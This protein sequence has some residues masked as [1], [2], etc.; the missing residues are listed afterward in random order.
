ML[1]VRSARSSQIAPSVAERFNQQRGTALI[2]ITPNWKAMR[3]RKRQENSRLPVNGS[4]IILEE[5][6]TMIAKLGR[7]TAESC[8][9]QKIFERM[10]WHM[11]VSFTYIKRFQY[12]EY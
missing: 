5:F 11:K 3:L 6:R 8:P 10:S 4:I 9:T 7:I 1:E 2:A 12:S